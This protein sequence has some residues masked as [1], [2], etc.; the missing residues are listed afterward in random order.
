MAAITLDAVQLPGDLIWTDELNWV[1]VKAQQDYSLSGGL[2]IQESIVTAGRPI[3][4]E[5]TEDSAWVTRS[6]L[7]AIIAKA[8][9]L[10]GPNMVLTL[11]DGRVFS[12][13]FDRSSDLLK[14]TAV[15]PGK[16]SAATD[17]YKITLKLIQ[18]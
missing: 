18:V 11:G 1:S 12:V 10:N 14:A 16:L 9:T 17:Y 5:S 3:T 7:Q 6:A 15:Q 4:L 2:I 13:R 8:Q